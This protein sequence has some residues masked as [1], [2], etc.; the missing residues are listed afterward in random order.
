MLH[1]ASS[2]P[3]PATTQADGAEL[4]GCSAT[5]DSATEAVQVATVDSF[6]VTL[7]QGPG[8]LPLCP[9][10]LGVVSGIV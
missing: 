4:D 3:M 1:P 2:R 10:L 8:P 6:Q 5:H 7:K 9:T